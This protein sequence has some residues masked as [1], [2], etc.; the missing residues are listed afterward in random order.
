MTCNKGHQMDKQE[1]LT[2]RATT[3]DEQDCYEEIWWCE[4]CQESLEEGNL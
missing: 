1:V 2:Q 3:P 4:Q